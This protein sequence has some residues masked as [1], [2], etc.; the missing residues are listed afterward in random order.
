MAEGM[1]AM[2]ES[3]ERVVPIRLSRAGVLTVACAGAAE[4]QSF[5]ARAEELRDALRLRVPEVP[6]RSIRPVVADHALGVGAP[7][8]PRPEPPAPSDEEIARAARIAEGVGDPRLRE[9]IARAAAARLALDRR[10]PASD[11]GKRPGGADPG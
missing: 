5:A 1:V 3:P 4:A 6:L 10:D 2:G 11:R 7:P 9:L 8:A